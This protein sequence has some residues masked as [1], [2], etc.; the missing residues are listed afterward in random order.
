M[1][2]TPSPWSALASHRLLPQKALLPRAL[3]FP[4][5]VL[6][7]LGPPQDNHIALSSN[8]PVSCT[9]CEDVDGAHSS[10]LTAHWPLTPSPHWVWPTQ[11]TPKFIHE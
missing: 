5:E 8:C 9:S 6:L 7:H 3:G 10:Q 2:Q 11:Y 1:A 4:C